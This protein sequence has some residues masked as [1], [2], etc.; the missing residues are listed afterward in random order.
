MIGSISSGYQRVSVL[1]FA[2]GDLQGKSYD[3]DILLHMI[4]TINMF[5]V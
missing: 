3:L 1:L 4:N 2:Q 5:I